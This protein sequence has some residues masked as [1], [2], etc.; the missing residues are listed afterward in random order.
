VAHRAAGSRLL[1]QG[2]EALAVA[3]S[4]AELLRTPFSRALEI[5]RECSRFRLGLR[6]A[7]RTVE[8]IDLIANRNTTRVR[9]GVG[10]ILASEE[11]APASF[12]QRRISQT[13]RREER[14]API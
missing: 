11:D 10:E 2:K 13:V 12:V 5:L 4:R 6:A 9:R 1:V 8:T 3:N 7:F 14:V